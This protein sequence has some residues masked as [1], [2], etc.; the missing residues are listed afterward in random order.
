MPESL[1]RRF[2]Y[3]RVYRGTM[4]PPIEVQSSEE[5]L[6]IL[7]KQPGA[8]APL[9]LSKNDINESDLAQHHLLLVKI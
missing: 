3:Q 7:K 6:E 5:A 4:R 9:R 2:I 8:I 1:L